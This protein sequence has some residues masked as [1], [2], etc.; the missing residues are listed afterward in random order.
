MT[1]LPGRPAVFKKFGI[2]VVI[3]A[4]IALIAA[5]I[6]LYPMFKMPPESKEVLDA[7][8]AE[9]QKIVAETRERPKQDR[10]ALYAIAAEIEQSIDAEEDLM[11]NEC[12]AY[13]T[14]FLESKKPLINKL[15][16]Y[17][18]R[19]V[20]MFVDGIEFQFDGHLWS[21]LP[22]L[23]SIRM[24]FLQQLV[25]AVISAETE[26]KKQIIPRIGNAAQLVQAFEQTPQLIYAMIGAHLEGWLRHVIAFLLPSLSEDEING[27]RKM[28]AEL[29]DLPKTTIEAIKAEVPAAI[30]FV[31]HIGDGKEL[32]GYV[33]GSNPDIEED[34]EKFSSVLG[35]SHWI[36]VRQRYKYLS[37]AFRDVESVEKWLND[38]STGKP[39]SPM[40]ADTKHGFVALV[41]LPNSP[42]LME[43]V[44]ESMNKRAA[45]LEAM[46]AE[47]KRR[48]SDPKPDVEIPYGD[49][50]KIVLKAEYGCIVENK[51]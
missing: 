1:F 14:E 38:G 23:K 11:L 2:A 9:Y 3:L 20:A 12:P 17:E 43:K 27:V 34:L 25:L 41:A 30:E 31:D 36:F 5:A 22:D 37:I 51:K 49:G 15:A 29:P 28:L 33:K 24:I 46:D 19:F 40:N 4:A 42:M 32:P 18:D 16:A 21:E 6:Y 47:L 7:K 50:N 48:A 45:V 44:V 10:E 8:L 39:T 35:Q 26:E 13:T